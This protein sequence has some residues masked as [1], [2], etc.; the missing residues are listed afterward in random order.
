[1]VAICD[2]DENQLAAASRRFPKAKKYTDFRKM[3][4]EMGKSID[5]VTVSTP[6]HIHAVA[7]AMAMRMGKHAFVQK[8][9]THTL[10][11]ARVLGKLARQFKVATQMGNQGTA[12]DGLRRAAAIVKAGALGNVAEV[13]V[14]TN[15]P[16]W[17]QGGSRPTPEAL[18]R[19]WTGTFGWVR[20][21]RGPTLPAIILSNGAAG[22]IS[23]PGPWATWP[24][25]LSI[26]PSPRWISA[27]RF[28]FRRR[29]PDTTGQLPQLVENCL[30]VPRHR[31]GAAP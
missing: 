20:R 9:L 7:A 26:C 25:T 19:I 1:M 27:T 5:A 6:D 24:A 31:R 15:R 16:I 13:H 23:A 10:H 8:P 11:E 17:P 12:N 22:G 2:V 18:R 4:D 30:R 21:R 14:W 3:L 28:P 29:A